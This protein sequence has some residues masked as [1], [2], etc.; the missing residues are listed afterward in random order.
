MINRA[1]FLNCLKRLVIDRKTYYCNQFPYNCGYIYENGGLS[2]DCIGMVKG[3]INYTEIV[4]KYTPAGFYIQPGTAIPDYS[5]IQ[6]LNHCTKKTWNDFLYIEPAEYLYMEGHGAFYVGELFGRGSNVNVVEC[7]TAWGVN[8]VVASWIDRD[9]T[10]RDMEGGTPCGKWEAHG[11]FEQ[12]I[13][14]NT[15]FNMEKRDSF[16]YMS[17]KWYDDGTKRFERGSIIGRILNNIFK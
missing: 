2:F 7:T 9:G 14:F 13:D 5:E 1:Y 12:Y 17:G 3:M 10:R 16:L 4:D 6:L 11:K 8:G 15:K